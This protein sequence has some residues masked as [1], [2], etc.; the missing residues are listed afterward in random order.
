[1][2]DS[3][4]KPALFQPEA[5]VTDLSPEARRRHATE[6]QADP[7]LVPLGQGLP[8]GRPMEI[9][10]R[11]A[12]GTWNDGFIHA[13]NLAYMAMLAIFPFFILGAGVVTALGDAGDSAATIS[14][15]RSALPPNVAEVI[16]PVAEDVVEARGGG[17]L[18]WAGSLVAIWTLSSLIETIR[19]IL[20]RA[21]G[22]Q[23]TV[24]FLWARLS[25]TGII[26]VAMVLLLFALLAQVTIGA[27]EEAID[28]W[29]P[30]LASLLEAF[31]LS[32]GVT[33]VVFFFSIYLLFYALTP[34]AYRARCYP[35]WP[36][37]LAVT[38]WWLAVTIVFPPML[39]SMFSYSLTYGSLAG[40]MIALFFFW[41]IGLGVVVGAEL[42][43]ALACTP[44]E[45]G[46]APKECI[47]EEETAR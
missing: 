33:A 1:M 17:W 45:L 41:L 32:R 13:G 5:P 46:E 26:M 4:E 34:V 11:V 23:H 16:A 12:L 18:L 44:E 25:S 9:L 27:A 47:D 6:L 8:Q 39:R 30:Q 31:M 28:V 3:G 7:T 2:S 22:T 21:Y 14:A 36:G 24:G 15:V 43:A 10:R 38:G 37:A 40:I 42:N 20:R 29:A 19:D 35:K